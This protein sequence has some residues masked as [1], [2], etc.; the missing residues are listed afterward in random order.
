[1]YLLLSEVCDLSLQG[2]GPGNMGPPMG[3]PLP[4]NSQ[5]G[6]HM[7]TQGMVQSPYQ[8]WGTPPQQQGY[9]PQ[10]YGAPQGPGG[11]QG[12]GASQQLQQWGAPSYGSPG[13]QQYGS[14]GEC[15]L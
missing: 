5:M 1:M 4:H 10:G 3:P 9:P 6:G 7:G 11:Y 8:G 2:M 13:G 15:W 12:W 14:F